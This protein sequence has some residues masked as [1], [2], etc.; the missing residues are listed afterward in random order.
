MNEAWTSRTVLDLACGFV[1][2][3]QGSLQADETASVLLRLPIPVI[4][5]QSICRHRHGV[6]LLPE[7]EVELTQTHPLQLGGLRACIITL[8]I[9]QLLFIRKWTYRHLDISH[10]VIK[11]FFDIKGAT[12]SL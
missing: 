11:L 5:W 6:G 9:C 4:C 2:V 12:A 10:S 3:V 1:V 7:D 8:E